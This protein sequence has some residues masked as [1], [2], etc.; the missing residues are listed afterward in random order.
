MAHKTSS[1]SAFGAGA[2]CS[3]L[4]MFFII[5]TTAFT[6]HK[7]GLTHLENSRQAAE[8]LRP[9]AGNFAALLWK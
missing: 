8:A 7:A 3:N 5:L 1:V 2:F 4:V 9:L 6:L